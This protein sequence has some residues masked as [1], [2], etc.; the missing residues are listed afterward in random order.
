M[1]VVTHDDTGKY[2]EAIKLAEFLDHPPQFLLFLVVE[3]QVA[4]SAGDPVHQM[5]VGSGGTGGAGVIRF[6]AGKAHGDTSFFV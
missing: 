6:Q 3:R 1:V 4:G 5:V 2:L